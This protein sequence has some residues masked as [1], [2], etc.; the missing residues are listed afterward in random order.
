MGEALS[1]G[2]DALSSHAVDEFSR[3]HHDR[4]ILEIQG[5]SAPWRRRPFMARRT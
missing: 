3:S 4:R 2:T 1:P 5:A